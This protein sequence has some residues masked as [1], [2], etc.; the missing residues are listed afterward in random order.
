MDGWGG[1][2]K[3]QPARDAGREGGYERQATRREREGG[4]RKG[5]IE[6]MSAMRQKEGAAMAEDLRGHV[7]EMEAL[8]ARVGEYS[9]GIASRLELRLMERLNRLVGDQVDESRLA[10]EAAIQA[11]KADVSEELARLS[12][13]IEQFGAGIGLSGPVGRRLDFLTQEMNREINTVGSKAVDAEVSGIVVDMK[14][15]L[16]RMR[17]QVANVE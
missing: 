9:D 7:S 2:E 10:Q 14:S 1:G 8:R 15:V 5:A 12:S 11:D 6:H 16:E 13:H 4:R 17:E 3:T